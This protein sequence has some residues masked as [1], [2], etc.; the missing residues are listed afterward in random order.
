MTKCQKTADVRYA[1]KFPSFG[2]SEVACVIAEME[3]G[4]DWETASVNVTVQHVPV[5][6]EYLPYCIENG[7][8]YYIKNETESGGIPKSL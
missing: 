3:H 6:T 5:R 1:K 8:E 2:R 7:V 4:G